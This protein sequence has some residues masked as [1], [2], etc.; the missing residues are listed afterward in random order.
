MLEDCES[1]F[2]RGM[3]LRKDEADVDLSLSFQTT[4]ELPTT[5]TS[6]RSISNPSGSTDN[7]RLQA[8]TRERRSASASSKTRQPRTSVRP[9]T[10]SSLLPSF[11]ADHDPSFHHRNGL[12]RWS[13]TPMLS[14]SSGGA[15]AL[16]RSGEEKVQRP[17]FLPRVELLPCSS[18]IQFFDA[19]SSSSTSKELS[20]PSPRFVASPFPSAS[21]RSSLTFGFFPL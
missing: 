12:R 4:N 1:H 9:P 3:V 19:V 7:L 11:V 16:V 14:T 20:N 2:A 18:S 13:S 10:R 21:S 5:L 15:M 8:S 17:G 6:S